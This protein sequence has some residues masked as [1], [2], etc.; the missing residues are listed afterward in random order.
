MTLS[1]GW[2]TRPKWTHNSSI[3]RERPSSP[4]SGCQGGSPHATYTTPHPAVSSV[5]PSAS[6][7]AA[8]HLHTFVLQPSLSSGPGNESRQRHRWLLPGQWADLNSHSP[9]LSTHWSLGSLSLRLSHPQMLTKQL[10]FC[11]FAGMVAETPTTLKPG[12]RAAGSSFYGWILL[13][14][15]FGVF[16]FSS[17]KAYKLKGKRLPAAT[18]TTKLLL[19]TSDMKWINFFLEWGY[20]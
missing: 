7:K 4:F 17:R 5:S 14:K 19:S 20:G 1:L 3:N 18:K 6:L 16:R 11:L 2:A 13:S 15:H 8:A 10:T 12:F 9:P